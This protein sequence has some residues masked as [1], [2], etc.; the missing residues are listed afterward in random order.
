PDLVPGAPLRPQDLDIP[1]AQINIVAF[2]VPAPGTFGNA[3]RNILKGPPAYNWDF[4]IFKNFVIRERT[5]LQFRAETFNLFNTPQFG[6]PGAAL[7]AP[8]TFGRSLSTL[9][10]VSGFGTNR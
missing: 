4:S 5:T 2:R 6:T 9:T 7:N 3:G 10:T 8:A 1:T